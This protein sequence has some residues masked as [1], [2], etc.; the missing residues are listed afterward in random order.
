MTCFAIAAGRVQTD[1]AS[2]MNRC[3]SNFK[4]STSLK[5]F[6]FTKLGA[7]AYLFMY[8]FQLFQYAMETR[9]KLA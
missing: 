8:H 6:L 2:R 3:P 7:V 9:L 1:A 5:R 4:Q